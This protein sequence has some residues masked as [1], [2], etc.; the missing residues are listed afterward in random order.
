MN[1][2]VRPDAR[3]D[4]LVG[5]LGIL[6]RGT[7]IAAAFAVVGIGAVAAVSYPGKSNSGSVPAA[8]APTE[9]AAGATDAPASDSAAATPT[10]S[11]GSSVSTPTDTPILAA[12]T[13]APTAA[14]ISGRSR[15]GQV[16]SGSS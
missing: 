13:A 12:P 1:G 7:P 11:T 14:P 6:S 16:S 10:D 15:G 9:A 5:R 4:R 8:A 2:Y 3:R